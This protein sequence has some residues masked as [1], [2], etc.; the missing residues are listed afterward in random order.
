[1]NI[2]PVIYRQ[3]D[4]SLDIYILS[5]Q[6]NQRWRSTASVR[7]TAS[8]S[9]APISSPPNT[10]ASSGRRL[11]LSCTQQQEQGEWRLF[12]NLWEPLIYFLKECSRHLT[13]FTVSLV[14]R[15]LCP[16]ILPICNTWTLYLQGPTE[17]PVPL[18]PLALPESPYSLITFPLALS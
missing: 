10:G 17:G 16:Y 2:W 9:R 15:C 5:I 18:L 4:R 13:Y 3:I 1:M 6:A 14:S 8:S 7:E 11:R 12:N